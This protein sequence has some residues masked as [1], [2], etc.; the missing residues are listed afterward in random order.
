MG[1]ETQPTPTDPATVDGRYMLLVGGLL[2]VICL[3]SA[4]LWFLERR[5]RVQTESDL[6]DMAEQVSS[7]RAILA[8]GG[9][10][11]G[12]MSRGPQPVD[13]DSLT[14]WTVPLDGRPRR[15]LLLSAH[16]GRELGFHVGDLVWVCAPAG[17]AGEAPDTRPASR[18]IAPPAPPPGL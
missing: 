2:L 9:A 1:Q 4:V 8:K 11:G 14:S 6:I 10:L 15:V 17:Q 18:P 13:R 12:M 16:S 7:L 5:R 3:T